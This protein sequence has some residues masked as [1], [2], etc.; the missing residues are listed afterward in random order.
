MHHRL[1]SATLSQ[2]AF[3]GEGN[4]NFPCGEIPVGRYSCKMKMNTVKIEKAEIISEGFHV[5]D[6]QNYGHGSRHRNVWL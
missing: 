3:P 6:G 1:G 2:M 5:H 4:P